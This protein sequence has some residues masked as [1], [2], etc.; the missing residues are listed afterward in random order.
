MISWMHAGEV[1]LVVAELILSLCHTQM[2]QHMWMLPADALQCGCC[3]VAIRMPAQLNSCI[4]AASTFTG[5][6]TWVLADL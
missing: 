3:C 2:C 4:N 5:G 1:L 6:Y